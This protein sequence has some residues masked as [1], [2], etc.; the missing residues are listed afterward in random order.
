MINNGTVSMVSSET[1]HI[2]VL[3]QYLSR[4][5]TVVCV[6]AR[7]SCKSLMSLPRSI[8]QNFLPIRTSSF[9][10]TLTSLLHKAA[11]TML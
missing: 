4:F 8:I 10:G 2:P 11:P 1:G 3:F 7:Q 6:H 5:Q 9:S